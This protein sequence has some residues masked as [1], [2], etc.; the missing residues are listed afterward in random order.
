MSYKLHQERADVEPTTSVL[1][2]VERITVTP[3]SLQVTAKLQRANDSPEHISLSV[4]MHIQQRG[5]AKKVVI[6]N[7]QQRAPDL[8]LIRRVLR[9][10]AEGRQNDGMTAKAFTDMRLPT[11][12][13][14]QDALIIR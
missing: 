9:A 8:T 13:A 2:F 10:I 11:D 14:Q 5:L 6:T 1:E 12:W 4:P 3:T 7:S